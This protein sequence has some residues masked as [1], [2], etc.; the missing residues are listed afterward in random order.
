M[1][2]SMTIWTCKRKRFQFLN[3]KCTKNEGQ[4]VGLVDDN[5]YLGYKLSM[6]GV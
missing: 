4:Y 1:G 2:S 5:M 3:L 6:T